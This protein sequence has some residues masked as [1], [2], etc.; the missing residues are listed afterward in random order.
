MKRPNADRLRVWPPLLFA[1][2]ASRLVSIPAGKGRL[3]MVV[4]VV[5]AALQIGACGGDSAPG[6]ASTSPASTA[7]VGPSP[8]A[9][10]TSP[11]P[12]LPHWFPDKL[13]AALPGLLVARSAHPRL[14]LVSPDGTRT[15]KLWTPPAGSG[16]LLVDC[17]PERGRALV[18][19][20]DR[21][22]ELDE[23]RLVL[24]AEDGSARLLALPE[25]QHPTGAVILADGSVVCCSTHDADFHPTELLWSDGDGDW[26][27]VRTAGRLL[28]KAAQDGIASLEPMAGR[29]SVLV[30]TWARGG[31]ILPATWDEGTL[32][33]SGTPVR[34]D[35]LS[36]A[37]LG[38]EDTV[39][40]ARAYDREKRLAVDL[41]EVRWVDGKAQ[42][43]VIVKDGPQSSGHDSI[44]LVGAGPDGSALV[45][46]WRLDGESAP[47]EE[48][49]ARPHHLQRL[50]LGL[51]RLTVLPLKV[52]SG[53][54]W[55]WLER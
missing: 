33:A 54:G 2:R 10:E 55:L 35:W 16:F 3:R 34:S 14:D 49:E 30:M 31:A 27:P 4:L 1:S 45:L 7:S 25:K 17:D 20:W 44:T 32:T 43:R 39:L 38:S 5:L 22:V 19:I 13:R 28:K 15:V 8:V 41:V 11:S 52:R 51:G 47:T 29:R 18:H 23:G 53:D 37:P 40:M 42:R 24:L 36:G 46:G 21:R 48:D 6:A 26:Q 12:A 9:S 50:D